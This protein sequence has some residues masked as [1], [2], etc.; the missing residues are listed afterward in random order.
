MV[1]KPTTASGDIPEFTASFPNI[2]VS[3]KKTADNSAA[4]TP[5]LRFS[6]IQ[7][8]LIANVLRPRIRHLGNHLFASE[9]GF[10]LPI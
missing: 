4:R 5:A 7:P 3:P 10:D 9:I 1:R 6:I 8:N 2:G